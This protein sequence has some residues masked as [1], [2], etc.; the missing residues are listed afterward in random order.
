MDDK[1]KNKKGVRFDNYVQ[2]MSEERKREYVKEIIEHLESQIKFVLL[3][4]K[5]E[6]GIL[7]FAL[8]NIIS[9]PNLQPLSTCNSKVLVVSLILLFFSVLLFIIWACKLHNARI[10]AIDFYVTLDIDEIRRQ[11]YPGGEIWKPVGKCMQVIGLIL[12]GIGILGYGY[13]IVEVFIFNR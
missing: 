13:F 8:Y 12:A 7:A 10:R 3:F 11:H 4:V 9:R 2:A 1:E 5:L 6:I